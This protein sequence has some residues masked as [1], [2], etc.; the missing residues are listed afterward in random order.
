MTTI[1]GNF[2]RM[3]TR[4][5]LQIVSQ[6][7]KGVLDNDEKNRIAQATD[8]NIGQLNESFAGLADGFGPGNNGAG[9]GAG[10]GGL[11]A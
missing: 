6:A 9:G 4:E 7:A 10:D 1:A 3:N 11:L 5:T 2:D 8:E